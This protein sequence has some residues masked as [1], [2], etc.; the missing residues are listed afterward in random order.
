MTIM[1]IQRAKTLFKIKE[2]INCLNHL[3]VGIALIILLPDL[4]K[5]C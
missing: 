4:I 1:F 2:I 3:L 5:I